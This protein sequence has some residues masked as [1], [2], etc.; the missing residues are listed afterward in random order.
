MKHTRTLIPALC[1]L[2]LL[3][4]STLLF[5]ADD[6]D[7]ALVS[8]KEKMRHE[9]TGILSG[10]VIGGLVGGPLGA[11]VTAGFGA[12]VSEL[13]IAKKENTLI[14][15]SMAEQRRELLALEAEYRALQARHEIAQREAQG[16]RVRNASFEAEAQRTNR[17]L[18][19]CCS[20]TEL[21]L[22]FKTGSAEIESLYDAKLNEFA[23]L[24]KNLPEAVIEITGHA[25]R[26]GETAANLAL[27][28]RRIQAVEAR[29]RTLGVRNKSLQT[30]A[31]GES[32]PASDTDTLEN[33][34]F[35]RRVMVKVI[36]AGNGMLTRTND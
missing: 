32:R 19:S 25:D 13:T 12:W 21:S 17:T 26:R 4:T 9:T 8:D 14:V 35:D 30:S 20:D 36:T 16:A 6:A 18:P 23:S 1:S 29:L 24:V 7:T 11:V 15:A 3:S 28:Q 5:A 22:H 27:S 2:A 10:A 34:F 33:N 31:F